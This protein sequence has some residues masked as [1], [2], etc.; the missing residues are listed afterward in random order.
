MIDDDRGLKGS[1]R[2]MIHQETTF[3]RHYPGEVSSLDDP[4]G[5][6]RVLVKIYE[7][8]WSTDEN[9]AWCWPRDRHS[10]DVPK[11][12]EWVEVYFLGGDPRRPVYMGQ[13]AELPGSAPAAYGSPTDRVLFQDPDSGDYVKYDAQA[14]VLN[15]KM[16]SNT[17]KVDSQNGTFEINGN[18]KV[19]VTGAELASALSSFVTALNSTLATK[20]DGGGAPGTLSLDIT[21]AKT[22]TVKT[23]G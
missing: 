1:I 8:G 5:R 4:L 15:A 23:G 19:F 11:R 12:G 7:I 13:A 20:L 6:G 17:L 9:A 2:R 14:Q 10:M 3:L 22:T 21:S 16:G 18:S